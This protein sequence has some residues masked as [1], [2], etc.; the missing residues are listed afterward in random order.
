M[1][2]DETFKKLDDSELA[3]WHAMHA[4]VERLRQ[5]VDTAHAVI[6]A[7]DERFNELTHEYDLHRRVN[8]KNLDHSAQMRRQAED[9]LTKTM[10]QLWEVLRALK[11]LYAA[12]GCVSE[13]RNGDEN[14][15]ELHDTRREAGEVIEILKGVVK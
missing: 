7:Q 15:A 5:S 1:T 10:K 12:T 11:A 8:A 3:R 2:S 9:V 4:E 14:Y 13:F 6:K